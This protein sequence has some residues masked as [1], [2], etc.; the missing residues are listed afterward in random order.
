[1]FII[2]NFAF[3]AFFVTMGDF[4]TRVSIVSTSFLT[5]VAFLFVINDQMP[6]IAYMT[7]LHKYCTITILIVMGTQYIVVFEHYL[8]PKDKETKLN[9]MINELAFNDVGPAITK[10]KLGTKKLRDNGRL[11]RGRLLLE[12]DD[13]DDHETVFMAY[14]AFF[15]HVDTNGDGRIDAK[16]LLAAL[17]VLQL[18][19]KCLTTT[20]KILI[21]K[22]FSSFFYF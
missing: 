7:W 12:D 19:G 10:A 5:L 15:R 11:P 13:F 17:K 4:G 18:Q 1:L 20:T 6:R 14:D 9:D 3:I 16:E 2:A 8:D 22:L 21:I